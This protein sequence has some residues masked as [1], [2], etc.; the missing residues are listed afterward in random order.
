MRK[1]S[2]LCLLAVVMVLLTGG[3]LFAQ[4]K[5]L[6]FGMGVGLGKEVNIM[7]PN[8][9]PSPYVS[10]DFPSLYFPVDFSSFRLEPEIGLFSYFVGTAGDR[11]T[12]L[13]LGLGVFWR[14]EREKIDFHLG[15]RFGISFWWLRDTSDGDI[16]VGTKHDLTVGPAA[17]AE[18]FF[19]ENLSGGGEA[20]LLYSHVGHL[21]TFGYDQSEANLV[22]TKTLLLL[23]WYW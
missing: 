8:Q 3:D 1:I 20:Q 2:E 4:G 7:S 13:P 11:S 21:Y 17:G 22:K 9:A 15:I 12:V 16:E 18:Y 10:A 5:P 23:K 14:H 19:T 6:R